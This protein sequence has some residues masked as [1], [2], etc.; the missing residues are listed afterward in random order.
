MAQRIGARQAVFWPGGLSR[1]KP[2][3]DERDVTGDKP[4]FAADITRKAVRVRII[5]IIGTGKYDDIRCFD[6]GRRFP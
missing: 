2:G 3:R 4:W 6:G 1:W 5:G